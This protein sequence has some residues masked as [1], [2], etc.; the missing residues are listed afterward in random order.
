MNYEGPSVFEAKFCW[1]LY[2]EHL[3]EV[4]RC[5]NKYVEEK[6]LPEVKQ[7]SVIENHIFF[8]GTYR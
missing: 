1:T 6:K 5:I 8:N 4:T 2:Q 7:K 3:P